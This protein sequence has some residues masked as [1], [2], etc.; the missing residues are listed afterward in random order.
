MYDTIEHPA[1]RGQTPREAFVQGCTLHG[2][3]DHNPI[4]YDEQFINYTYPTTDKGTAKIN[5]IEGVKINYHY[6][7]SEQFRDGNVA[8]S[9]VPVRYD[10]F[11]ASIA[12][13]LLGKRWVTCICPFQAQFAG[14]SER[15]IQILSNELKAQDTKHS[16]TFNI[17][18]KKLAENI[19]KA[20]A[21]NAKVALQ[22]MKDLEGERV[23]KVIQGG[24]SGQGKMPKNADNIMVLPIVSATPSQKTDAVSELVILEDW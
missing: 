14:R 8:G 5:P 20:E 24:K 16:R 18:S 12:K 3:R 11:D 10:P 1:L 22:R 9:N 17:T 2:Y 15:E 4:L 23:F 13:V 19:I 21:T 7:W 6:Y